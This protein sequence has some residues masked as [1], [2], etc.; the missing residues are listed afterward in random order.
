MSGGQHAPWSSLEGTLDRTVLSTTLAHV[1][2]LSI[3]REMAVSIHGTMLLLHR[4]R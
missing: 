1:L 2:L 4:T 3:L